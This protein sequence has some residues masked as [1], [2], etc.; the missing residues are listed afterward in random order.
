MVIANYLSV[1]G[2]RV[3]VR[4]TKRRKI[5]IGHYFEFFSQIITL[6]C[7]NVLMDSWDLD[8]LPYAV[9]EHI[10]EL[11]QYKVEADDMQSS[12]N[13]IIEASKDL[14]RLSHFD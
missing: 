11:A 9:E 10:K 1:A 13:C 12:I 5:T 14:E 8:E 6:R 7:N 2:E 3:V 4:S